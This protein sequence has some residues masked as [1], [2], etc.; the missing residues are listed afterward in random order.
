[1]LALCEAQHDTEVTQDETQYNQPPQGQKH[2]YGFFMFCL[3]LLSSS[4]GKKLRTETL[5]S[6]LPFNLQQGR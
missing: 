4:Q 1:M 6:Y 3:Q 2:K 5:K